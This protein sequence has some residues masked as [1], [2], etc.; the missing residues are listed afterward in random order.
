MLP[1]ISP[2]ALRIE[3]IES[4]VLGHKSTHAFLRVMFIQKKE[5]LRNIKVNKRT[6]E[7]I[8]SDPHQATNTKGKN[9]Q[10]Q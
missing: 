10:I 8:Q 7:L 4:L 1:L 2:F 5:I 9:R 6:Q 3:V